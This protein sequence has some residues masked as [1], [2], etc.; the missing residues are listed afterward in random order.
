MFQFKQRKTPYKK[1]HSATPD[2]RVIEIII[3]D[4]FHFRNIYK[5]LH[6]WLVEEG[7]YDP[8]SKGEYFEN[9]YYELK[10]AN[11]LMF[12]HI[13]WR[14]L[15]NPDGTKGKY[16]RYYLKVNFQTLAM[17]NVETMIEGKKFKTYK[18]ELI[19]RLKAFVMVD[20]DNEWD[21]H[22]I[23]KHF[24]KWMIERW[25]G[26]DISFHKKKL[27]EELL[28]FQRKIKQYLGSK[29]DH[30]GQKQWMDDVTGL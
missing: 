10:K 12:H 22:P 15:K 16:F 23:I 28:L 26:K 1:D 20:P 11:G 19:V 24:Q 18:G 3:K 17:S 29:V 21:K 4:T 30:T 27:R 13:W 8:D 6:D 9:L 14:C 2:G 7:Y 25:L 5:R